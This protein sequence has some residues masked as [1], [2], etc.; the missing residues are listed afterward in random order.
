MARWHEDGAPGGS[1]TRFSGLRGQHPYR[2]DLKGMVECQGIEPC[3][4]CSRSRRAAI[5]HTPDSRWSRRLDLN[6][7]SGVSQTPED[8]GLLHATMEAVLGVEPSCP[9]VATMAIT[10][11]RLL[12]M[13]LPR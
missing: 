13:V 10:V 11:S 7:R 4:S 12:K 9:W 6:Q 5:A 2:L 1:R 8:S 3:R